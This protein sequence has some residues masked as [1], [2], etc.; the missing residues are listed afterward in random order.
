MATVDSSLAAKCMDFCHSLT[1][2]NKFFTF[3]LT[4]GPNFTFSL[5]TKGDMPPA[6]KAVRRKSPS[7][8]RRNER[9]RAEFL[10]R[11]CRYASGPNLL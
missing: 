8:K 7:A 1:S 11:I 3:S 9:R 4:I 2:Q 6:P 10:V 5:D